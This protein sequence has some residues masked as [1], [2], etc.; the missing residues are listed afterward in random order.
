MTKKYIHIADLIYKDKIGIATGEEKRELQLWLEKSDSNRQ[1]FDELSKGSTLS[2]SYEEYRAIHREQVWNRIEQQIAPR[3]RHHLWRW[4]GYAASVV[5]L[6]VAGWFVFTMTGRKDR[7]P[8]VTEVAVVTP[9]ERK[10]IL[11]LEPGKK[12]IL[13][14]KDR[15]IADD[16]LSGKIEQVNEGLVYQPET[17]AKEERLNVLEIPR[18]GEFDVTLADGTRVWLNAGSKL[19]YP[20]AFV[21]EERRVT[22]EGEGY[23]EVEKSEKPFVVNIADSKI[24]VYGTR[25][26]V[27]YLRRY[28]ILETVLVEGS[29]GFTAPDNDEIRVK[30][31]EQVSFDARSGKIDVWEVDTGY[32]MAWL[33]GAF[34]YQGR[35]LELVLEDLS[36]WYGVDFE[37]RIDATDLELTMNLSKYTP[38]EKVVSFLEVLIGCKIKKEG[39]RYIIE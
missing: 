10:A 23:F 32:A 19:T 38:V 27:K 5:V 26:N 14:S 1:I 22:L 33:N 28:S 6:V 15:L 13:D 35:G 30:P 3:R 21:G 39:G 8:K 20:V 29:I 4:V 17:E 36:A 18:G 31:G 37:S 9:G 24:R 12:V 2:R 11:Y 7:Q 16:S 25:F 34:K